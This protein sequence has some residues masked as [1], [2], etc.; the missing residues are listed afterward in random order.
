MK[1]YIFFTL[2]VLRLLGIEVVI[3]VALPLILIRRVKQHFVRTLL[4]LEVARINII[5]LYVLNITYTELSIFYLLLVF[6]VAEAVLGLALL[7]AVSQIKSGELLN[8]KIM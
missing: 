5:L 2:V 4:M 3:L 7:V 8:L 1:K 6:L